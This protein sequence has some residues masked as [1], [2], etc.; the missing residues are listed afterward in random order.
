MF[1]VVGITATLTHVSTALLAHDYGGFGPLKAN[2]TGYALA[3]LVSYFGH[4]RLTFR[5]A[6]FRGP[7]FVRF[8]ATSLAALALNQAIVFIGAHVVDAPFA[9]ALAPAV[10]VVPVVTFLVSKLW[11]FA[12]SSSSR[13]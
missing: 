6:A 4:A 13:V 3:V 10:V 2:F 9:W 8:V 11:A 5:R 12:D 7:Q 1:G